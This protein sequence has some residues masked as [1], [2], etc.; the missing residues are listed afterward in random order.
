MME[1]TDNHYRTMAQLILKHA[2]LYTEMIAAE[3]I[4]YQKGNLAILV[5]VLVLNFYRLEL[6]H[7]LFPENIISNLTRMLEFC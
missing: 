2:L 6:Y 1:W 4:V 7:T 3:T 5:G